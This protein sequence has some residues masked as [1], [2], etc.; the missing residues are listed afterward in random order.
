M[1]TASR[2]TEKIAR[3][4]VHLLKR[5]DILENFYWIEEVQLPS[6]FIKKIKKPILLFH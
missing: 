5:T 3:Q 1:I 2:N 4:T 6:F